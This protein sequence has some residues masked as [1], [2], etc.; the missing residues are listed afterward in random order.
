MTRSAAT[1]RSAPQ[2]IT[3]I[4]PRRKWLAITLATVAFLPA[5][6]SLL[7]GI[8]SSA[9][10]VTDKPGS[11]AA[12]ALGLALIPFV[13]MVL[14]FASGNPR[15][16]AAV[17][18]AMVLSLVVGIPVSALAGDAITGIVAGVG[19]G[20]AAALRFEEGYTWTARAFAVAVATAYT[21]LL[22]RVAGDVIVLAAPIFPFTSIGVADHLA[23]RRKERT[24]GQGR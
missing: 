24:R 22:V 10:K 4:S 21:F 16:P 2:A 12:F 19:A 23:E 5:Y 1:R 9:S 6:W 20:G 7:A 13:F 8:V 14:A 15:A 17:V 3:P 11:G 18:R